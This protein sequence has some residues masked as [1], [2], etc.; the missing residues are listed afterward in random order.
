MAER[1]TGLA[2]LESKKAEVER[3]KKSIKSSQIKKRLTGM[4][5]THTKITSE[6]LFTLQ[7]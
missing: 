4:V 3:L 2:L 1:L 7:T 5:P 6:R